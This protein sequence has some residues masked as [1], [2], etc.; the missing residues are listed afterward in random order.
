MKDIIV[1]GGGP[2]GYCAAERAGAA[3]LS[4]TLFEKASL[5]GV[6]LNEGC[7]P[8]KA[9]LHSAKVFDYANG[10]DH[11][12]VSVSGVK[13]DQAAVIERKNGVVKK[14][15]AGVG[16][17]MKKNKV[18]VV[19]QPATIKGR[20]T[21]GFVVSCGD[22]EYTAKNLIIATGSTPI[23]PPINGLKQAIEQNFALTNKEV[24]DLCE[25]PKDFVVVGG[26]VIGLEMASYYNSMGSNV[27]VVEMLPS[28][29]GPIDQDIAKILLENYKKKGIDFKLECKVT[30]FSNNSITYQQ[31]GE[32]QTIKADKVLVSIGRKAVTDN[33]G[34]ET[35]GI[36]LE[37]GNIV[38]DD[39]MSTNVN[40]VYAV[41]DVNGKMMLA[42]TAYREAEVAVS[43]ILGIKDR[44]SYLAI[45]SVIYTNPEVACVGETEKT[46]KEKGFD[47]KCLTLPMT[48]SGRYIAENHTTDGI[49][50]LIYDNKNDRVLGVSMIG[51]SAS[52]S[53]YG[54]ALMVE[55]Q[56]PLASLKKLVF[57]HPTVCE[58]IKE[59]LFEL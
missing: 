39:F 32:S 47:F 46:A 40:G 5:G 20:T 24:L 7:V 42:H 28:I 50:K 23:L 8:S 45:P 55:Q 27:T 6:C 51:N 30:D 44:M 3:G 4:V 16:M 37:R 10:G 21:G 22:E 2:G 53:I 52:E 48:Y 29:G 49:L 11:Y 56:I 13:V 41:G 1:I 54:V 9:L 33:I 35:L 57:P 26:G 31:N 59:A 25:I 38:T 17:K 43:N 19:K 34:L 58:V 36:N 14:L 15:V 12:G 18:E